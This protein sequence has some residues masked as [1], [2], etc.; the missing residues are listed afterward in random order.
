MIGDATYPE[1]ISD[2][3]CMT[4]IPMP[5]TAAAAAAAAA[6]AQYGSTA[7][8]SAQLVNLIDKH[9][10]IGGTHALQALHHLAGHGP[11]IGPPAVAVVETAR[12]DRKIQRMH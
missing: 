4:G 9:Q 11:H 1:S 2:A 3:T 12:L 8:T 10:G 6:A 7:P 5:C